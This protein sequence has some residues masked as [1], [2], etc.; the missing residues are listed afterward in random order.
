MPRIHTYTIPVFLDRIP[1]DIPR[2]FEVL[3]RPG[4]AAASVL[5]HA[6]QFDPM[7]IRT[8]CS[9]AS[10]AAAYAL[11]N[12]FLALLRQRV[13]VDD[14]IIR[15]DGT[16]V[17]AISSTISDAGLVIGG[18]ATADTWTVDSTWQFLLDADRDTR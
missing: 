13:T 8:V 17:L 7:T 18:N 15:A 10:A 14:G 12:R 5:F 1:V 16:V 11:A 4:M 9:A 6:R 2:P 3:K